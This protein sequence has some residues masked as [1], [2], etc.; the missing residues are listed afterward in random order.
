VEVYFADRLDDKPERVLVLT[1]TDQFDQVEV[2]FR[3]WFFS[4]RALKNAGVLL[5]SEMPNTFQYL[6]IK[7]YDDWGGYDLIG[8]IRQPLEKIDYNRLGDILLALHEIPPSAEELEN[9]FE[10]AESIDDLWDRGW[11]LT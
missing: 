11:T 8:P 7:G 9:P 10:D 1:L 6:E 4:E 5:T 3:Q 2:S